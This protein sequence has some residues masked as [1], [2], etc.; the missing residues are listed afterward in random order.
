[1]V[2]SFEIMVRIVTRWA[3]ELKSVRERSEERR[4]MT[5]WLSQGSS[6]AEDSL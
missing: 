1:V 2:K 4:K 6:S 5:I 3:L